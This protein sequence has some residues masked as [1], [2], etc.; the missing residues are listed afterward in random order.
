MDVGSHAEGLENDEKNLDTVLRSSE[1][2]LL[3]QLE[4]RVGARQVNRSELGD[5]PEWVA[6]G[7]WIEKFRKTGLV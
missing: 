2:Q 6:R 4:S 1:Q 5:M 3:A 7:R